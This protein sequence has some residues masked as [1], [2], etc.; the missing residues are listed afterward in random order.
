[1]Y[2][3]RKLLIGGAILA[4]SVA[5]LQGEAMAQRGAA[6]KSLDMY[7]PNWNNQSAQRRMRHAR[8]YGRGLF[9]YSWRARSV[10]PQ[11][12]T[13]EAAEVERNVQEARKNL[14]DVRKENSDDKQVVASLESIE[15][16]L[17]AALKHH[18]EFCAACATEEGEDAKM[19]SC[20]NEMLTEL[21]KAIAE[22]EALMRR[23]ATTAATGE[24]A[25]P[26]KK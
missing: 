12:A 15:K 16:H 1:M 8:D 11:Y 18:G 24:T 7:F 3:P 21:D 9:D 19:M 14:K 6:Q 2:I 13:S 23:L 26:G 20:C 10:N 17:A 4:L 5:A 25:A 22:H